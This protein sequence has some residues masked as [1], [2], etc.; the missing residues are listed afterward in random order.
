MIQK[1]KGFWLERV[2]GQGWNFTQWKEDRV[3]SF[4]V[5]HAFH[6]RLC[7]PDSRAQHKSSG[8]HFPT[9]HCNVG[10]KPKLDA[11]R[12]GSA[13][14]PSSMF[15]ALGEAQFRAPGLLGSL[16]APDRSLAVRKPIQYLDVVHDYP[17][18]KSQI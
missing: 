2:P 13:S 4:Q 7:I 16:L 6:W 8:Y 9:R 3:S 15:L 10:E 12:V 17:H 14:H 11:Q 1:S 18:C 5:S